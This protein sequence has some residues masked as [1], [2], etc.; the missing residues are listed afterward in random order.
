MDNLIELGSAM[1][2]GRGETSYMFIYLPTSV[3]RLWTDLC[4]LDI[5]LQFDFTFIDLI[6]KRSRVSRP[7]EFSVLFQSDALYLIKM[8]RS[9]FRKNCSE[10]HQHLVAV[11]YGVSRGLGF[12]RARLLALTALGHKMCS[13]DITKCRIVCVCAT[14]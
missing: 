9:R 8:F 5:N 12:T 14:L 1:F 7:I 6:R 11:F 2:E 3:A 4:T 13:D 10:S